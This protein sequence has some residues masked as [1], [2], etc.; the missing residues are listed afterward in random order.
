MKKIA[1]VTALL[2]V[3]SVGSV[4][5]VGLGVQGGYVAGS[6]GYGSGAL[7]FKLDSPWIFAV[8]ADLYGTDFGVGL[9][10][11]NWLANPVIEKP[12]RYFYGWGLAGNINFFKSGMSLFAGARAVVGINCFVLDKTLEFYVQ[13]A[14]E[15]GVYVGLYENGGLALELNR[16]PVNAGFRF[17][18]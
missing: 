3:L 17:W 16:F 15:P 9:T 11:D 7:T 2:M 5:A 18:F 4:F 12:F 13:A 14:W 1:I 6:N 10:M 8:N